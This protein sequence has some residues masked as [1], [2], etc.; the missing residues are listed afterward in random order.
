[1]NSKKLLTSILIIISTFVSAQTS[2]PFKPDSGKPKE[3]KG[4]KLVWNEKFNNTYD[5][6]K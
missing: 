2:D 4:M 3:I 5:Y 6:L 1:M